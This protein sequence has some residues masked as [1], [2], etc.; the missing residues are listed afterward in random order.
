[1]SHDTDRDLHLPPGGAPVGAA[2]VLHPHPAMGGDRHHPLVVAVAEGLAADGVAA[3]RVDLRDPDVRS[4]ASRLE[5]VATDLVA[6]VDTYRLV[7][8]GYS[9]G[10]AVSTL[11]APVGLVARVL[12]APPVA[13][14]GAPPPDGLPSLLLVPEHDQHG[15]REAVASVTGGWPDTTLEVVA[16]TD[17][18]LGGAVRRIADRTVAWIAD[19]L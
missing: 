15:G 1:V 9:W 8:V 13:L 2:V 11:A 6:E 19:A 5:A 18:F 10:S 4:S 7:L 17:H 3:L 12:I 14:L 16:G